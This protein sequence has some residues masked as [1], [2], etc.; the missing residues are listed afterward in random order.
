ML[1]TIW[2]GISREGLDEVLGEILQVLDSP[3][4]M[5]EERQLDNM[6]EVVEVVYLVDILLLHLL[7][8]GTQP[9]GGSC[10]SYT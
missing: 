3:Y 1:S 6:E 2:Q 9:T 5:R 4:L 7:P 8:C 10:A